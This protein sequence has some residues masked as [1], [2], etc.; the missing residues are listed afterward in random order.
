MNLHRPRLLAATLL[1]LPALLSVPAAQ[2]ARAP[3]QSAQGA[4]APKPAALERVTSI[5]GVTEYRLANGLKILL[6]PDRSIDTI[7]VNVTYLVGSRHEG[8]GETGM[9]HLLE[10]LMF[11]GTKRFPDIK[12]D[13][14][15]RGARYNGSTSFDRTNY[16][17]IF[18][19]NEKTLDYVLDAE[20]DRMVNAPIARRDLDA[21]MTVVRN[22]FESGENSPSS[23]LRE[24]VAASAYLWHN[25]GNAIIGARSDIENV[26]I[27]RLKAFYQHYYQPD[28][29]VLLLS[30]NLNE[31]AAL[32][33]VQKHFGRIARPSRTLRQ[34]YTVEPTQDGERTV[35]LRRSGDVQIVSTLYHIPPGT[36]PEYAAVDVL[37]ALIGHVPSGRLHKALVET[38]LAS[39][40][41][42]TE[43]QQ[44]EAGFAYF[45]ANVRQDASLDAARDA[46]LG[47]LEGFA[48]KPVTEEEVDLARRRLVNDIELTLAD[49]REL[50]GILSEYAGV[51]DWRFLYLYRDML[52]KLTAADVQ[53]TAMRYLKPS[54]RTLGMFLP[55]AAPDRAEIPPVPDV[56]A[57]LKDYRGSGTVAQ[58]EAFNPTPANIEARVIR[59]TLPGGMRLALLPK[60]TRGGTVIA[61]LALQWGDEQS[62]MNRAAACGIT[63][64]M[65]L[66]GTQKNSREQLRNHFDRLKANVGV[67]GDGGSIETV[68][69][70]LPE[71]LKL[72]A[73]VLRQPSFPQDEFEQ[74]RRSSLT[75][76]D[77]QR[78]DPSAL[79]GLALSRHLSPYPPAHWLYTTTLEER[80]ARL[81]ALSLDEVRKCYSDFY[82]ASDSDLAVVGDFDPEEISRLAQ[83]LFGDWKSPQPFARI[84]L[85]VAEVSPINSA[86][87]TPDKANAMLRAGMLLRLR[88]D[89]PD[90]PALL[91]ANYVL[92]G[93]S[94]SRLTRRIR[95]KEGLSYSVGS[96]LSADSFYERGS[97]G[98]FAIYAPQ[99]RAKV[100]AAMEEEIRKAVAAGFSGRELEAGKK[101]LL[102]ARQLARSSDDNLASR[103]VSYLVLDR[104]L[105]WDEDLERKIAALTPK[106]V[107]ETLRRYI[108]PAKLSIVKA[109]DFAS[110]AASP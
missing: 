71:T 91:L 16:F 94:D 39:S 28:N 92:G 108:D 61:Q 77:T 65:L 47:V 104:T 14:Q 10:H 33:L 102:Q 46:L 21:E 109:G 3:K 78:S 8:Y 41:F 76:I 12:A 42:G 55:T 83:E 59:K 23:V 31:S 22:E 4:H 11:R 35:T 6:I 99:N 5:E 15:Q 88:D 68:R 82:G 20:A 38:G 89:N 34:T 58:G 74:L 2:G 7:M 107:N 49:S 75:G 79:A 86:I 70:N 105:S 87:N 53:A 64:G 25:Y 95:E 27:E 17:E 51:G 62:K 36:H 40:I 56:A 110:V 100:E 73:E 69:E 97:F 24:R 52:K 26:P 19:A 57:L 66:R 37:V 96:F 93:S 54:N 43:R 90:Y 48:R 98:V 30:G 101:G 60:K 67:N 84:P 50:T 81:Q 85:R 18:T 32:K 45:G 103:L 44:H 1:L 106:T 9:A 63:G 80:S 29:A 13:F 72:M